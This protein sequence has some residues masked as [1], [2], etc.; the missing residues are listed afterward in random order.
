[1]DA[2]VVVDEVV[3]RLRIGLRLQS[4]ATACTATACTATACTATAAAT[5]AGPDGFTTTGSGE[6]FVFAPPAGGAYRVTV[7]GV[8]P[9]R[10]TFTDTVTLNVFDDITDHQFIDEIVWLAES[11]ITTGCSTEPLRY[12]PK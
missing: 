9:S 7:T 1:M 11:G 5:A 2:A 8:T 10:Q 3:P 6:R 4:A 12:C